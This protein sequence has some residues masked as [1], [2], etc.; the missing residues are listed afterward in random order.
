M[1][2]W[3]TGDLLHVSADGMPTPLLTLRRGAADHHY[4]VDQQLL[5]IPLVLDG[6]IRAYRWAPAGQD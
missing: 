2:D 4:V 3:V 6:A 1:T 5:V